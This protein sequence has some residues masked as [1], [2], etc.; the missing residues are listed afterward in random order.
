MPSDHVLP[1]DRCPLCGQANQC[2]IMAGQAPESCWCMQA[3][4]SPLALA[5]LPEQARGK[6]CICP[7]CAAGG[8]AADPLA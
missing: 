5:R 8:T 6:A 3:P 1:A 7:R 2:A 4:V